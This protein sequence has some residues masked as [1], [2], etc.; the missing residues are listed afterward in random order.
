MPTA[1]VNGV[2]LY[3]E[4]HGKGFP[5]ILAHGAGGNHMSWWQQVPVLSRH[6]RCITF[7][8]RGWGLSLDSDDRGPEAFIDDLEGLLEVLGIEESYLVGQSMGGFTCL[9]YALRHPGRV[10]G[11]VMANTFAGMRR[12]VWLASDDGLRSAAQ[13]VWQ[14]RREDGVKR[15]LGRKFSA[16]NKDRAF[17]YKQI[18]I[19]NE[20]GPNRLQTEAQVQRFRALER[21]PEIAA[22]REELGS[23]KTPVLFVGGEHDEVMPVSLMEV[24]RS[25][26][27]GARMAVVEHAAHSVYFEAPDEFNKLVLDF[28]ASC[29]GP[30]A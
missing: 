14:R 19:L 29:R 23:M 13:A 28:F 21:V 18:R 11:L 16:A 7:D 1:R 2:D 27:P 26:I 15:A 8:H 3:Y 12:E 9:S 20:H 6:Y 10:L 17:L 4:D 5:V 22:G 30:G 24:A 25:L